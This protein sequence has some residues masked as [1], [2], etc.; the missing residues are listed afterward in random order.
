MEDVRPKPLCLKH[1]V[2]A[3]SGDEGIKNVGQ[4]GA[5]MCCYI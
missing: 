2:E 3:N 5:T 1:K 4:A